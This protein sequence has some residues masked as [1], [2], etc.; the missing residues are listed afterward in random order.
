VT[1]ADADICNSRYNDKE[2]LSIRIKNW[3]SC[4]PEEL[5]QSEYMSIV[6]F[7]RQVEPPVVSSPFVRGIKGPG[8]IAEPRRQPVAEDDEEFED[9]QRR[10]GAE[11]VVKPTGPAQP[12][13]PA[14]APTSRPPQAVPPRPVAQV[15]VPAG[16]RTIA[17]TLGGL[18]VL[19]QMAIR[20]TLPPDTG[21]PVFLA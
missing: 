20:E 21:E 19:D 3:A 12:Q 18:Q 7:D 13:S 11:R 14:A 17:T 8:F 5:R 16:T 15:G 1:K 2:W 10:K 4:I 9:Q 6:P